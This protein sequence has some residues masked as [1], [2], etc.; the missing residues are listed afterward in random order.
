MNRRI[1]PEVIG[2]VFWLAVG[3]FFALGGLRLGLGTLSSPGPGFLPV[4]MAMFLGSFSLFK[5]VKGLI[6]PGINIGRIPW[7]RAI[8]V[9]ASVFLFGLLLDLIGFLLS[10]FIMMFILFGLL[11]G[12]KGWTHVFIYS[13]ITALAAWLVFSVALEIPFP[14]SRLMAMW[15]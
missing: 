1:E 4:I 3:I 14:P 8:W 9:I 7:I 11:R 2:S 10:T 5:I 12:K 6:R 15:R 13:V